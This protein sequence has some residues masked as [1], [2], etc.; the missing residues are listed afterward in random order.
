MGFDGNTS[1]ISGDVRYMAPEVLQGKRQSFPA[2][3]WSFGVLIY[4]LVTGKLPFSD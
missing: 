1:E 2:D 4:F 3:V